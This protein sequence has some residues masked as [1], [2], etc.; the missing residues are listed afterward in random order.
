MCLFR[1]PG[2]SGDDTGQSGSMEFVEQS[3]HEGPDAVARKLVNIANTVEP[4]Q[5]GR[6]YVELG[7]EPI[8]LLGGRPAG[9]AMPDSGP[10]SAL[11]TATPAERYSQ[12]HTD[13][14]GFFSKVQPSR[15][16][17]PISGRTAANARQ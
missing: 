16:G 5:D 1:A 4:V 15:R 2:G 12:R 17:R 11:T 9:S 6:I 13:A 10:N 7:R 14:L 3:P 8:N